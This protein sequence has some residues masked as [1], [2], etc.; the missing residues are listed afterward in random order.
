M[1]DTRYCF[2]IMLT[3]STLL[4]A[5][6]GDEAVAQIFSDAQLIHYLLHAE[7]ALARA[8][9]ALDVIPASAAEAIAQ[10]AASLQVDVARLHIETERDGVPITELVRQLREHIGGDA[11]QFVHWGAT[12]Q[13]ILDTA[14]ILQMRDALNFIEPNLASCILH[15]A[16]LADKHRHTLM[17]GRTHSQQALPVTFGFKV[18][19]WLA[20]LLR[21]RERLAQ[22][23][24]RV[25]LVQLGGAVGTLASLGAGE[26]GAQVQ[27]AFAQELDLGLPMLAWHTQR[28]GSAEVANWLSLVSGSLAKMAQDIILMAQ[29]EVG[30]LSES[31]DPT[32]GGSSTMPQ[33]SNPIVSERIVAAARTNA[34]L[35]ANMHHALIQEHERGT[36]GWQLEWLS[37]PQMFALTAGA[38]KSAIFLSENLVVNAERM[39]QNVRD[40]NGTMLAERLSF[41]LATVMSRAKAKTLI[42]N[43][44]Q[45]A[46][47]HNENLV[48]VVREQTGADLDWDAL[49]DEANYLGA[50]QTFIDRV[51]VAATFT[52]ARD[53]RAH[54]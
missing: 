10:G 32:R 46:I 45:Y 24:P 17:A 28:D 43:A 51:L 2:D 52:A 14:L 9:A 25:L 47:R 22:F 23:L 15:L 40:S 36:H 7:V 20:P 1:C 38:L 41:A 12:T 49:R 48:D 4:T 35:L 54:P 34:A 27:A 39:R 37:L 29:S 21:H 5:Q 8:E 31:D 11:A 19:N 44:G 30:E 6:F 3:Q 26:I 50:T 53:A 13:D 16:S 18:A 33:K 42:K